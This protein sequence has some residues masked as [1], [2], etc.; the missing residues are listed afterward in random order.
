MSAQDGALTV[1]KRTMK[2]DTYIA[3]IEA[4]VAPLKSEIERLLAGYKQIAEL[5]PRCTCKVCEIARRFV[6]EQEG[7][8]DGED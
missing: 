5:H 7:R 2:A 4:E 3:A 6:S 8:N 1:R